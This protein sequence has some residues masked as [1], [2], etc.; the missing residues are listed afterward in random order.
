MKELKWKKIEG[1]LLLVITIALTVWAVILWVVDSFS[2]GVIRILF[3]DTILIPWA[4][5][6]I[7]KEKEKETQD[8]DK[9]R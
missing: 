6:I 5:Q 3:W 7:R 2:F 4:V 8:A 1:Y 9:L